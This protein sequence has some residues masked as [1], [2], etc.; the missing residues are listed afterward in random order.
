MEKYLDLVEKYQ[1]PSTLVCFCVWDNFLE[2]GQF[3]GDIKYEAKVTQDDRLAYKGKG[4]KVTVLDG[5]QPANLML[6]EYSDPAA[7]PLWEGLAKELL[8]R[9]KKRGMEKTMLLGLAT[10]TVP[11]PAVVRFWQGLLPGVPWVSHAHSFR[12]KIDGV[13]VAYTSGVWP[14]RFIS[15]RRDQPARLEEPS[16]DGAIR[17]RPLRVLSAQRVPADRRAQHRRRPARLRPLRGGFLAR[18]G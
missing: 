17:P 3:D 12:D 16:A 9:M 13:P 5:G 14:P 4:P 18:E 6:P 1:G 11:A 15:L 2:G 7:K 8:Q 10:D